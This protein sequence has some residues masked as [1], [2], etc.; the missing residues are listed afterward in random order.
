DPGANLFDA[1]SAYIEHQQGRGQRL[2][3]ACYSEGSRD[4]LAGLLADHRVEETARPDDW[5]AVRG[6]PRSAV[7]LVVLGL[8][9]GFEADGLIVLSEQDILGDRLA[10]RPRRSRRVEDFIAEASHLEI[11]DIVVHRDHGIGR[12]DGLETIELSGARH[13]CLRL[14]YDGD[15]KLYLPV[16]N[17]ELLSRYGSSDAA[18]QLDRLGGVA[19]QARKARLKERI[20]EMAGELLRVAAERRLR[21]GERM[22]PPEG[23]Y[24]EF[25]ARFPY[26]ETE[27]QSRA[28]EDVLGDLASGRPM[29]R[30]ICGDVGFG[31]TEVA[32]RA[33][34]IAVMEGWQ[35]AVVVPTTLLC[36]QHLLTFSERFE[37]LPVRIAQLSRLV[38]GKRAGEV[39]RDMAN[40]QLD[41]VIG[42]HALLAKSIAFK[43][44][45]LLVIDEEQHF[46]V[47][48]KERLKRLRADVHVMTLTATPIPRTLQ[49][50]LTGVR[51][52]SLMATPPLDRLAVRSFIMPYDP[53]VVRE[54][55]LREHFRGGQSFFVCPRVSDIGPA[56]ERLGELVP[57]VRIAVAHGQMAPRDLENVMNAFYDRAYDVLISTSII[58]SGL[59]IPSVNTLIVYRAHM[60]GLSQLYQLRGRIGRSKLRAYAYFTLPPHG[61]LTNAA[62]KRL[63]V[64]HKLDSLGAGFSLASHD[65][66]I[67]GAGNLLGAEQSGHIREVGLELF[68]HM[69][70]EAVRTARREAGEGDAGD[71]PAAEWTPQINVGAS[72]LIPEDYVADLGVRLALYRRLGMLESGAEIDAF[73]A[74]LIDRFGPLPEEVENLLQVIAIKRLC[75]AAGVDKVDA[76]PKGAV[77]SFHKNQFA[78]PAELVAFIGRQAGAVKLRPDHK[79]VYQRLWDDPPARLRGVRRL[80]DELAKVAG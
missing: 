39:R 73:A 49:M 51:E 55:I 61:G 15:D 45:G 17:I 62:T 66:D 13:D 65:L 24:Q 19:W 48:H 59:D 72:V 44:L 33:A 2:M 68:Q 1:L 31:K 21:P 71:A 28:I 40:G 38:T 6:L 52:L 50:A 14:F 10:R 36:R 35:V 8:D 41:I 4:R 27:D 26:M 20:K 43:R 69:L 37:G 34:F 32:L 12:F 29:D 77:I 67:R 79:L 56:A 30:L 47:A 42:T 78:K 7:A 3:I 60:F 57:E 70:E 16:E 74:E 75:R 22:T 76:G 64:L 23:L 58:E 46:G 18:V 5:K 63:E 25:A 9:H 11:D 54:A 53:V 80:L